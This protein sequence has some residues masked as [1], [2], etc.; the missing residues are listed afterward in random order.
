[1]KLKFRDCFASIGYQIGSDQNRS[2]QKVT[3]IFS[4]DARTTILI[5]DQHALP[6]KFNI[7]DLFWYEDF[8]TLGK[9]PKLSPNLQGPAKITDLNDT[10]AG[11]LLPNGKSKVL[12]VMQIK[13]FFQPKNN[14]ETVSENSDLNFNAEPKFTGPIMHYEKVTRPKTCYRYGN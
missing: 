6:H 8:T 9:N 13:K 7:N 2:D 4:G 14:G 3:V 12:N 5:F 11:V 1:M 10:N